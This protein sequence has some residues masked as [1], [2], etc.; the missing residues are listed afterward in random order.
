MCKELEQL[1]IKELCG[2][3]P[4][5]PNGSLKEIGA[6]ISKYRNEISRINDDGMA[7]MNE[8]IVGGSGS[9]SSRANGGGGLPLSQPNPQQ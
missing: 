1:P 8:M 5:Q 3:G 7:E 2:K 4:V 6:K 9:S